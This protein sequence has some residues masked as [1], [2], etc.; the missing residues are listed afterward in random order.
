[1]KYILFLGI[2]YIENYENYSNFFV[3][4]YIMCLIFSDVDYIII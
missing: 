1:M 2:V 3:I 4:D